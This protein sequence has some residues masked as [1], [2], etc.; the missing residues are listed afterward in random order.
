[1]PL[2]SNNDLFI[3][4]ANG[5]HNNKYDY[6]LVNYVNN[7]TPVEIVCP[8]HGVF[9]QT[10]H[11]HLSGCGCR[12]C[13]QE[14]RSFER[15]KKQEDFIEQLKRVHGD[16]YDY[17]KTVYTTSHDY[18]TV[19]CPKHG[20]F[21]ICA[22]NHLNGQG[23]PLCGNEK[24]GAYRKYTTNIFIEKAKN[25]HGEKY[26][27]SKVDYKGNKI[28]V[29]IICPEHGEFLQRPNDHLNGHGCNE[30]GKKFGVKEKAILGALRERYGVVSYQ[31]RENF[32]HSKTSYKTIDF[33]L[34]DYK[35]G[36]EYQGAQHFAPNVRFGGEKS[37]TLQYQRDVDKFKVCEE[38]GIKMFYIS[39]ENNV[40]ENYFTKV[41]TSLDDLLSAIDQYI[42]D[43]KRLNEIVGKVVS[44]LLGEIHNQ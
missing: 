27:Y 18:I 6:S 16:K 31:Y 36:V 4:K 14:R 44:N 12:K 5:V 11:D 33:Y 41:Y 19:T 22:N 28:P 17:S 40:P 42:V 43:T 9:S 34:P 35:I 7:T 3:S 23:C 37:Y 10:P 15:R 2:K 26:D 25:V 8:K 39:F 38:N 24:K 21:K 29:I 30:C 32:L 20:D 13:Y 1:M